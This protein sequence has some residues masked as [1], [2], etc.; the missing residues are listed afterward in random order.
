MSEQPLNDMMK[1][2]LPTQGTAD[3]STEMNGAGKAAGQGMS[4]DDFKQKAQ[5][6]GVPDSVIQQGM[7]AVKA[8]VM[9]NKESGDSS[10][11]LFNFTV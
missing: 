7:Q 6:M 5:S 11:S 4:E 8:W 10:D 3:E 2:K 1:Q 9:E